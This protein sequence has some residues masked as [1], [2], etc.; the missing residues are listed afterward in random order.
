MNWVE[1]LLQMKM[2]KT[3]KEALHVFE[4]ESMNV[5]TLGPDGRPRVYQKVTDPYG[6]VLKH[7]GKFVWFG[8]SHKPGQLAIEIKVSIPRHTIGELQARSQIIL[9][10]QIDPEYLETL[11]QKQ[12]KQGFFDRWKAKIKL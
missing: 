5:G 7:D 2:C 12:K 3:E 1:F 6:D 9:W 10:K 8:D 11:Q 4:N